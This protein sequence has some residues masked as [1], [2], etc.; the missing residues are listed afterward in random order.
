MSR[1]YRPRAWRGWAEAPLAVKGLV[2]V[3]VPV[4]LQM[5]AL[6]AILLLE[7]QYVAA[8]AEV[9]RTL[10]VQGDLQT[11]HTLLAEAAAG[12]R[13]YLLTRQPSFLAPRDRA[14]RELG[15]V[16]RRLDERVRDPEQ[17]ARLAR[18]QPMIQDKLDG[19][20]DLLDDPP[21]TLQPK[22]VTGKER[23]DV[24]RAELAEA[25]RRERVLI[26]ERIVA[27][28]RVRAQTLGAIAMTLLAGVAGALFAVRLFS[29]SVVRRSRAVMARAERLV[30]ETPSAGLPPGD[31]LS[32]LDRR[33]DEV[34]RRLAEQRRVAEQAR[35]EAERA[36][37][38]KTEFL[39]RMSH[40]LR[41]PL[42]AVLGYAQLIEREQPALAGR[43][44]PML[45]AGA[46]LLGLIDEVLD[47]ARIESGRL[48]AELQPL[49]LQPLL[50]EA[51]QLSEPEAVAAGVTLRPVPATAAV[52]RADRARLRQILLN[53][54]SNAIKYNRRDGWA[55]IRIEQTATTLAIQ[56][57]DS[58]I[59]LSPE[60][61]ARLF[62]P[63]ER[64]NE[65]PGVPGTGLGLALSRGLARVM[66]GELRAQ[67]LP[68]GGSCFELVLAP[69]GE[70][71]V[72]PR[73]PRAEIP[74][75]GDQRPLA[76]LCVEDNP[77]NRALLDLLLARHP[78]VQADTATTLAEARAALGERRYDLILLDLHLPDGSGEA[79]L[80]VR[81]E[82]PAGG[83]TAVVVLS[84]DA[85]PQTRERLL[86][87]GADGFLA[88]PLDVRRFDEVLNRVRADDRSA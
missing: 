51:L 69:S 8:E 53:L 74:V 12:V 86:A 3:G 62:V 22:L 75:A 49:R 25:L 24:M 70:A 54:L 9:R 43:T 1:P 11:L 61:Q 46:H 13:G 55:E 10:E 82:R 42:N 5:A 41:T 68:E 56:V 83:P 15:E 79:L 7:R 40:E 78:G 80:A 23:L 16:Q 58:G 4:L 36:S 28:S 64:G 84:A 60:L 88:K 31:E 59:G 20:A 73:T 18:L 30:D 34:G 17:R 45:D 87:A 63:F 67:P 19:W 37:R 52:V 85:L 44:R 2:M 29:R 38:A 71:P 77:A 21:E 39:S 81:G 66:G 6:S 57:R 32:A 72:E 27:A 26:D 50:E 47:L 14:L 65:L 48:S 76:V 35:E 33:L